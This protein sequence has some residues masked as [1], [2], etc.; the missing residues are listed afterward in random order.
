MLSYVNQ[1]YK[2]R[3]SE[4]LSL[5]LIIGG[6]ALIFKSMLMSYN[7]NIEIYVPWWSIAACVGIGFATYLVVA[8][9]HTRSIRRV[10]LSEAL[11]VQE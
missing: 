11:K 2:G 3:A 4:G 8:L 7:G 9:L 10:S 5:L 6:L 1:H